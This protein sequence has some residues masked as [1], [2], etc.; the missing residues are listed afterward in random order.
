[1]VT[2]ISCTVCV[3][4]TDRFF[5]SSRR[6]H[7]RFDCDWSSD[8]CSSDLYSPSFKISSDCL[9]LGE[10]CFKQSARFYVGYDLRRG[11][12]HEDRRQR[13]PRCVSE[14]NLRRRYSVSHYYALPL[15]AANLSQSRTPNS[16]RC[17]WR[18]RRLREC[19]R[20]HQVV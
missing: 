12:V 16:R 1:M 18:R 6:R 3:S 15:T 9:K 10:Y 4:L 14:D 7:T 2:L 8:V 11:S 5:F 13:L 19:R 20:R 17:V